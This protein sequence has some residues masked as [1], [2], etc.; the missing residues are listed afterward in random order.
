[1]VGKSGA[2]QPQRVAGQRP[3]RAAFWRLAVPLLFLRPS[4]RSFLRP[5]QP[6]FILRS[7][8]VWLLGVFCV[9]PGHTASLATYLGSAACLAC[10][11]AQAAQWRQSHHAQSM[12]PASDKTVLGDFNN[13]EFKQD[14]QRYRFFRRGGKFWVRTAGSDGKEQDFPVVY[15]FGVH[16]LQQYLLALPGGRLQALG[17]AWD[18]RP[19][20]QGG[21][22]WYHL[23]PEAPPQPG[24]STHWTGRDQNW[25]Y[26]CA[27]C[28]STGLRKN[29]DAA[30][31]SYRTTFSDVNVGCEA[32]H[33]SGSG[34]RA[35]ARGG[36]SG[37]VANA[38]FGAPLASLRRLNFAFSNGPIAVAQGAASAGQAAGEVCAGC[39]SR[40]RELV[41]A[42]DPRAP[43][44]D[45]YLP[46]LLETGLYQ[47]DGRIDGEVFEYGS[48][49]QS[50]M[51]RA[52]VTCSNCHDSH[53]LQLRA[54]GNAL[55]GQCHRAE[56]YDR[57]AHHRHAAD[58]AGA[59]CVACHM[60]GKTYMGVHFRRDHSLRRPTPAS[61]GNGAPDACGSCHADKPAGWLR[62][63]L[64][65][66]LTASPASSSTPTAA[67]S[68][69]ANTAAA[70]TISI[71]PAASVTSATSSI[72]RATALAERPS[73]SALRQA[74]DAS[75]PLLRLGAARA[76][77]A[78]PPTEAVAAGAALLG[79][80]RR[81]VRIEAARS[82][83]GTPAA[84]WSAAAAKQL[85]AATAELIASEQLTAERPE[86]QL[87]L[88]DIYQRLGRPQEA[89][90]ALQRA[91]RLAPEFMPARVNLADLYRRQQRDDD[92]ENVLR[93]ALALA[94]A[95][96]AAAHA[97]GLLLIRRGDHRAALPWLR[98]AWQN[99]PARANYALVLALA[100]Q[101]NGDGAAGLEVLQQAR[102][103]HPDDLPLLRAEIDGR[104]RLGQSEAARAGQLH[105]QELLRRQE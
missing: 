28:H 47:A 63:K 1:M 102:Q 7:L 91:I 49:A 60:P 12:Q 88:G 69:V 41:A 24:E 71:I 46:S 34:H 15:T 2:R 13:A 89:E 73:R 61:I 92:A 31:D 68:A 37:K 17:V 5:L 80:A 16:P 86:S 87:N 59:A 35:W 103:R 75:D 81:A 82:L 27:A 90:A 32:C 30:K 21:Q 40:R 50:A 8:L 26:M 100:L 44:L 22:R 39:H 58:S 74:V 6:R 25:N 54:P 95:E 65:S 85:A 33:G 57:P 19:K 52:G 3:W 45:N 72:S 67:A 99:A 20:T 48:F 43:F 84:L 77:A 105:L 79:D 96:P 11:P 66:W 14:G 104:Q 55:C 98:L 23:Y 18:A 70:S 9:L 78:L 38:G 101:Q 29:Y 64:A 94:P 76:L 62:E 51:H 42:P 97:L 56:H 93:E 83:L 53:S 10:H 4:L 36:R